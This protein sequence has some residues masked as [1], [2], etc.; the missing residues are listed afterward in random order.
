MRNKVLLSHTAVPLRRF[1][2]AEVARLAGALD[3][4]RPRAT[5]ATVIL[6]YRRPHDLRRAIDSAL[7]QTFRDQVVMVVDDGGG[8]PG[9][10]PDDPRLSAVSLSRNIG[11]AGVSRNVGIRLTA[12]D[13]V[14]FL[15]DDNLWHPGHLETAVS[16]LREDPADGAPRP[17]AVYTAMRRVTPDGTLRDILSVPFDRSAARNNSFLDPNPLVAR[18]TPELHFSRIRRGKEVAPR[19]DWEMIFR[20]SR[21]H[22]V[23]HVPVP[24]VD[25]LV[26]PDSYWT[27]WE[28][29]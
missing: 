2:D 14:A 28:Q 7:G 12:S 18:R 19:E 13:Y 27:S 16:R 15:D 1:E 29:N 24:T 20:Y 10:L 25:Y 3:G 6:T 21:R 4:S 8:L 17:D 23:E 9:D 22:R 5:V 11:V 26:N